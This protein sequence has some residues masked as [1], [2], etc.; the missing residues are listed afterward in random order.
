MS[1]SSSLPTAYCL[2]PTLLSVTDFLR[3]GDD[4][5][6]AGHHGFFHEVVERHGNLVAVDVLDR[7]VEVVERG[8][9]DLLKD[10]RAHAAI[11]PVLVDDHAAV[12]L[13]DRLE[14][15]RHVERPERTDV[16]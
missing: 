11:A 15:R 5:V 4:A 1:S 12:R 10:A 13:L 7:R 16:D 9:V 6:D 3:G 2:L 8:L 14:D